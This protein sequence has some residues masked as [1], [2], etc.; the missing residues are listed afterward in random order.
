MRFVSFFFPVSVME[1]HK[2]LFGLEPKNLHNSFVDILVT[3]RCFMKLKFNIDLN[4]SCKRFIQNIEEMQ[5]Y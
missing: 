4:N 5:V 3:L 2:K 1:L